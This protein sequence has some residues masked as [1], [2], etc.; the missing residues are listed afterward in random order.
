V[1]QRLR[2]HL[3]GQPTLVSNGA[4]LKR[5]AR[6]GLAFHIILMYRSFISMERGKRCVPTSSITESCSSWIR[7]EA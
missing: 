7:K 3:P 2:E 1:V 4:Q 6:G 5:R